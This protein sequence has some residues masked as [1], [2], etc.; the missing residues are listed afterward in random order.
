MYYRKPPKGYRYFHGKLVTFAEYN[1]QSRNEIEETI[2]KL[3]A[4]IERVFE[5]DG[6]REYLD[7]AAKIPRYSFRNQVLLMMQHKEPTIFMGYVNWRKLG[8]H[9]I[10]GGKGCK[11]L[12]PSLRKEKPK[13]SQENPDEG[14][15]E[16][17]GQEN[18]E[19]S[20]TYIRFIETTVF[21]LDQTE[22]KPLPHISTDLNADLTNYDEFR[23]ALCLASPCPVYFDEEPKKS[24]AYAYYNKMKDEIHCR[25]DMSQ[26]DICASLIHEMAHATLHS[27]GKAVE[28]EDDSMTDRQV[29]EVE[30]EATAYSV[31]RYFGMDTALC[32]APYIAMYNGKGLKEKMTILAH[33]QDATKMLVDAIEPELL[34]L[35]SA[36]RQRELIL[37]EKELLNSL[38][39]TLGSIRDAQEARFLF[40]KSDCAAVY[41]NTQSLRTSP[42]TSYKFDSY[43]SLERRGIIPDKSQHEFMKYV[44]LDTAL[45]Y[46]NS[47]PRSREGICEMIFGAFHGGSPADGSLGPY[48]YEN[49]SHYSISVGDVI[50]INLGGEISFHYCDSISW[51]KLDGFYHPE[52]NPICTEGA[53]A[54]SI[55]D[56]I[57]VAREKEDGTFAGSIYSDGYDL[58]EECEY[59]SGYTAG[60]VINDLIASITGQH[61]LPSGESA[62][63][64]P[65]IRGAAQDGDP[66]LLLSYEDVMR[67]IQSKEEEKDLETPHNQDAPNGGRKQ[68]KAIHA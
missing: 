11:I 31:S 25:T 28:K 23:E 43:D 1:Q 29:K 41:I 5:S 14:I 10:K 65:V 42:E 37:Q 32:S 61:D 55:A 66:S 59:P 60:T 48:D 68:P 44:T 26:M 16:D 17:T 40:S 67:H 33:I 62:R 22:G 2:E 52:D 39:S 13:P 64:L 20:S 58:L 27:K 56:R 18:T 46:E 36:K 24:G 12:A 3:N 50:G 51:H 63:V 53:A 9:V 38:G 34:H 30:A 6:F 21:P 49:P 54:Y 35:L 15:L 47:K 8:R 45:K 4:E 57:L 7:F 19:D